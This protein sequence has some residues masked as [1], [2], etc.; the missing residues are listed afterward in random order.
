M[1]KEILINQ[2][3]YDI[4]N[5]KH[6]GGNIINFLSNTGADA[7]CAFQEFHSKSNKA[8]HI[9]NLLKSRD[10]T[11]EELSF[12]NLLCVV[13]PRINNINDAIA[14][15]ND[16]NELRNQLV[17]E[18]FFNP[19]IPHVVYRIT[20]IVM[21]F[22]LA[23]YLMLQTNFFL[24]VTGLFIHGITQGRCGWLMHEAGHNSLTGI[25]T[26]DRTI[27]ELFYGVG[28]GMSAAWWRNQHN[29]H[30]ATPQKLEHDVDL[31]TLPLMAFNKAVLKNDKPN[32]F[33]IKYQA[34]LFFPITSAFV[35]LGWTLFLHPRHI[36]RTKRY[37]EMVCVSMR[38]VA[39]FVLCYPVYGMFYTFLLYIASFSIACNYIF[40]NFAVSHTHLPVTSPNDFLH[41][42]VYS[43]IH[44]TNISP[45][46]LCN[47][48][49]AYL[50]FQIEHH[51]FPS[52]PQFK[53]KLISHRVKQLFEKHNLTYDVRP[54][55]SAVFD[56]FL[57][58]F[59]VSK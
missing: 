12:A 4:T 59:Y 3:F 20:E 6:P 36:M 26:I 5:F 9:L 56:T 42:V 18:G 27:Q 45:N 58:L 39:F 44:T 46:F 48:W 57:N 1:K 40:I 23:C 24:M 38:Y 41:W 22:A 14:L 32:N 8:R 21:M 49:M 13:E 51:L 19:S 50:N 30:H 54:Y 17:N 34:F 28:C 16:F 31:N 15:N 7:S 10:A 53:H 11:K 52:M 37:F 47:W 55:W 33:W 43:S 2:R 35:G 25:I 29:K